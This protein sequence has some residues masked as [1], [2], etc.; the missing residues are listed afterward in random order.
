MIRTSVCVRSLLGL[1]KAAPGAIPWPVNMILGILP[2]QPTPFQAPTTPP[3]QAHACR[4]TSTRSCHWAP[5]VKKPHQLEPLCTHTVV[6][7]QMRVQIHVCPPTHSHTHLLLKCPLIFLIRLLH[8]HPVPLYR[9]CTANR[10]CLGLQPCPL[11]H[12]TKGLEVGVDVAGL[13]AASQDG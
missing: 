8:Q 7:A 1:D 4:P 9:L 5:L 11:R 6:W 2:W 12:L 10:H 3:T 13:L